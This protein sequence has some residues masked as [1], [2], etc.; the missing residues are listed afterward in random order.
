MIT[1]PQASTEAANPQRDL[2][3]HDINRLPTDSGAFL[4]L[5]SVTQIVAEHD[6]SIS[7]ERRLGSGTTAHCGLPREVSTPC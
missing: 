1:E 4:S 6:G 7:V 2:L 3:I 5:A